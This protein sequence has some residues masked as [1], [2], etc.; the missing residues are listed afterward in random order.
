MAVRPRKRAGLRAFLEAES[1]KFYYAD[2]RREERE[3][4]M[5]LAF[6]TYITE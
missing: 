3:R 2:E 5:T 6:V 4:K 1:V